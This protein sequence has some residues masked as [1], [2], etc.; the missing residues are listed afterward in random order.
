[1]KKTLLVACTLLLLGG[2]TNPNTTIDEQNKRIEE[3]NNNIESSNLDIQA[4]KQTIL[5]KCLALADSKYEQTWN[6]LCTQDN[7]VNNCVQFIG[8][9]KDIE[10]SKIRNLEKDICLKAYGD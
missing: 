3:L 8:S 7:R 6:S 10:F 2:C 9:P 5:N 1:M 4:Q